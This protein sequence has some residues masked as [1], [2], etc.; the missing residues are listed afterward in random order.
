MLALAAARENHSDRLTQGYLSM[1]QTHVLY[2]FQCHFRLSVA[3][4][5]ASFLWICCI[6]AARSRQMQMYNC[7][8]ASLGRC[9]TSNASRYVTVLPVFYN[10][11]HGRAA[12]YCTH[13]AFGITSHWGILDTTSPTS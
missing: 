12:A 4:Y 11:H 10:K 2:S 3:D 7:C 5:L 6:N 1:I 13:S 9:P 8:A